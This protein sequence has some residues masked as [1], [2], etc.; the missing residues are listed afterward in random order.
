MSISCI[1]LGNNHQCCYLWRALQWR[2]NDRDGVSNHQPH[3]C[4]LKRLFR[5]KSKKTSKLRVTGLCAGNSP[6]TGEFHTQ[7]A[8]NPENVSIWWRH[9][10]AIFLVRPGWYGTLLKDGVI[11]MESDSVK[12]PVNFT[13]YHTESRMVNIANRPNF[14][15][16]KDSL[17]LAHIGGVR[18]CKHGFS[19]GC[20]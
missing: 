19:L 16:S 17:C 9:H 7:R 12:H 18:N 1:A 15:S 13:T 4:L 10:V 5:R 11:T 20:N 8:S 2:H 3:D 6:V 14:D